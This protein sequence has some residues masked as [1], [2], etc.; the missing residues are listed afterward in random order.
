MCMCVCSRVREIEGEKEIVCV[1][2]RESV[3]IYVCI[4]GMLVLVSEWEVKLK[5]QLY[6]TCI[7]LYRIN[8]SC[9]GCPHGTV[10]CPL[11]HSFLL[12]CSTVFW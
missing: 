4:L 6:C 9:P 3:Q 12:S 10:C 1:R 7:A 5:R 2:G 8:L 11:F